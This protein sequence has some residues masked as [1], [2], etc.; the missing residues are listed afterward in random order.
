MTGLVGQASEPGKTADHVVPSKWRN[1]PRQ[2]LDRWGLDRGYLLYVIL[3]GGTWWWA[4]A[5]GAAAVTGHPNT[6]TGN[7]TPWKAAVVSVASFG[8]AV[9][10][11][12]LGMALP[13]PS[14]PRSLARARPLVPTTPTI[15]SD[16]IS[17]QL[18]RRCRS[19]RRS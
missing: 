16:R 17:T 10:L 11:S 2:T 4:G 9:A 15:G 12:R 19:L 7:I 14:C 5:F 1:R 13:T 6:T 3:L 8:V 18:R